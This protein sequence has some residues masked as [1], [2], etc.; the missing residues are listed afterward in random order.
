MLRCNYLPSPGDKLS[1]AWYIVLEREIPGFDHTVNGKAMAKASAQL[2]SFAKEKGLPL[3]MNFFSMSPDE[4][5]GFA[6]DHG[7]SLE[8][9]P[10]QKWFSADDGLQTVNGLI[11]GADKHKLDARVIADLREFQ[12]VLEVAKKLDVRWHLAVDF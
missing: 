11:D 1:V 5:A 4:L 12:T 9:P 6:E 7:A 3:L 8:Q 2:D 10:P